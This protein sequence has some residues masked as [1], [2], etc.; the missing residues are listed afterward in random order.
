MISMDKK[1]NGL[2][3]IGMEKY[4]A[5][6]IAALLANIKEPIT[7]D[8]YS[9]HPE[10]NGN[11]Q[12]KATLRVSGSDG[13]TIIEREV[14]VRNKLLAHIGNVI[15]HAETRNMIPGN[16]YKPRIC[17]GNRWMEE[18]HKIGLLPYVFHLS[19]IDEGQ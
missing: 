13:A 12:R 14:Y 5:T 2:N 3:E 19:W 18:I 11:A 17:I 4:G 7:V 6:N 9:L 15:Q 10:E 16:I 8:G 1:A